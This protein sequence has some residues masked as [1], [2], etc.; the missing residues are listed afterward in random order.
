MHLEAPAD[1]KGFAE[2]YLATHT[3]VVFD[4]KDRLRILVSGKVKVDT[5][6]KTD[7]IVRKSLST[8]VAYVLPP[9]EKVVTA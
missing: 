7:V 2:S 3:I 8:S 1:E 5:Y 6:T 4:W 9:N